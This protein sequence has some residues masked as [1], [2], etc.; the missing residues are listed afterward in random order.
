MHMAIKATIFLFIM[1]PFVVYI[2]T[3]SVHF[4][5]CPILMKN[6]PCS[7]TQILH[8]FHPQ[9]HKTT[10]IIFVCILTYCCP[11]IFPFARNATYSAQ[12]APLRLSRLASRASVYI[13]QCFCLLGST[14]IPRFASFSIAAILSSH[15]VES[16]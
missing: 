3:A 13:F 5:E 11:L 6:M 10:S 16:K 12:N 1:L 15:F 4:C 9:F 7:L 14:P 2:F 8:H